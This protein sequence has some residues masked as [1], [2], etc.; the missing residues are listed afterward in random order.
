MQ[1]C[2]F[3]LS[4]RYGLSN[5]LFAATYDKILEDC[6]CVP[7]FHTMAWD[8]YPVI[9]SG[10]RLTWEDIQHCGDHTEDTHLVVRWTSS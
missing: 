6:R 5:C 3:A 10:Q 9:C 8:D 2:T 4:R 7:Y 1:S